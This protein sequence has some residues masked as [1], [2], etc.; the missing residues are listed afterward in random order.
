MPAAS[1]AGRQVAPPGPTRGHWAGVLVLGHSLPGA[2]DSRT[3]WDCPGRAAGAA[4]G[5]HAQGG[6]QQGATHNGTSAG[7]A[8]LRACG[9]ASSGQGAE[10]G[11]ATGGG[12]HKQAFGSTPRCTRRGGHSAFQLAFHPA[13]FHRTAG[14]CCRPGLPAAP[15]PSPPLPPPSLSHRRP[16]AFPGPRPPPC[17]GSCTDLQQRHERLVAAGKER[18]AVD[19]RTVHSPLHVGLWAAGAEQQ[20]REHTLRGGVGDVEGVG[21]RGWWRGV[22]C[23]VPLWLTATGTLRMLLCSRPAECHRCGDSKS[24]SGS[25]A[26]PLGPRRGRFL[27]RIAQHAA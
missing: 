19:G 14:S 2:C 6:Q 10:L 22:Q 1:G 23:C 18:E 24:A 13:P 25:R 20:K 27:Q 15:A 11:A 3:R 16:N 7:G 8:T 17:P 26:P 21:F 5:A 12:R 4:G 9:S